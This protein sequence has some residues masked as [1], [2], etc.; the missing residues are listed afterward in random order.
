MFYYVPLEPYTER[1]TAQLSAEEDGWFTDKL[2]KYGVDYTWVGGEPLTSTIE[3]GSVLDACGRGYW[4][5]SQVMKLLS[6]LKEG[7]IV[8]GDIIYFEDFW[9][10]GIS[11]LPY[12]RHLM[13]IDFKMYAMIHAQS[14]DPFDFT[15]SMRS[16]MRHFEKGEGRILEGIFV[17]SRVLKDLVVE[18][19]IAEDYQVYI[20]GLPYNSLMVVNFWRKNREESVTL[21]PFKRKRV[22][23]T[24]R[25]DTEKNPDFFVKVAEALYKIDPKIEC[26]ATTSKKNLEGNSAEL[27]KLAD[28]CRAGKHNVK[29]MEGLTKCEYYDL[30]SQAAVQFNCASQDFVSW[31]LLEATHFGC[32]PVYPD[33]LSFPETLDERFLY[34]CKNVESAVELVLKYINTVGWECCVYETFDGSA[35]RMLNIMCKGDQHEKQTCRER[36]TWVE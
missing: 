13:G 18:A 21:M 27:N 6:F 5:C 8:D 1:Y 15:H 4:A 29:V 31:T 20:T 7:K 28:E 2:N 16:W 33:Y 30:L 35:Y 34:Q 19:G 14:V 25:W 36:R 23:F 26:T 3:N 32:A 11:A 22:L 10:P 17:T 12:A 24:S 9:H